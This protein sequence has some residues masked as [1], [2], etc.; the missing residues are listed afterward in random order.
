MTFSFAPPNLNAYRQRILTG[1]SA[2]VLLIIAVLIGTEMHFNWLESVAGAYL[3]STNDLRPESGAIWE[4]GRQSESA[5]HALSQHTNRRQDVQREVRRASSM[6]QV[7]GG[8]EDAR[9]AVISAAHFLELYH[10]LPPVLSQEVASPYSLLAYWSGG[11][12]QRTFFE[13]QDAGLAIYLLDNHS[14]V[15]LRLDLAP[16]LVEHIRRGEVAIQTGLDQ[17]S[18]FSAH[19]YAADH[20]F[21]VLNTLPEK[22]REGVVAQPVGLLRISGKIKRV[23]I[24]SESMAG[25]VDIGFEVEDANGVKVILTQ[26]KTAEVQRLRWALD[27]WTPSAPPM[28]EEPRS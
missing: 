13:F 10:K 27:R 5:R 26:G 19:I 15:L 23:G 11:K 1:R 12:W 2:C 21:A 3:L 18:D 20:F 22:V 25:A 7:I 4:Q 14:Q 16:D 6:G 24:S 28:G 17:L 8:I 9:G